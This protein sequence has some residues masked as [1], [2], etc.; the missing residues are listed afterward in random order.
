MAAIA[1]KRCK[2]QSSEVGEVGAEAVGKDGGP[3]AGVTGE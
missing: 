3:G 2:G 1:A